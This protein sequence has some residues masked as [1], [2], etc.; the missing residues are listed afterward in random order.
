MP[1][2]DYPPVIL[3]TFEMRNRIPEC[4]DLHVSPGSANNRGI[5]AKDLEYVKVDDV[6]EAALEHLVMVDR[7]QPQQSREAVR[8]L[9]RR[10]RVVSVDVLR[11][12]ARVYEENIEQAPTQAVADYFVISKSAADKRVKRARDAGFI[13]ST[14]KSG[15]KP[16]Q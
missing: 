16:Q 6:L 3:Y 10:R 4:T 5:R 11:E 13:T 14:A 1:G 7:L 12:V 15:R 9:M 8:S 2:D